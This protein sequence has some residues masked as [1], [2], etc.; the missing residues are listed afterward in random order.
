[1]RHWRS[2]AQRI[3]S[4]AIRDDAL[5]TIA[6]KRGH[7]DGAALFATLP[8]RRSAS[9]LRLLV[10]YELIWDFLDTVNEHGASAGQA[11]GRQL[12]LAL[13][14][15]VDP[16]RPV[17]DYYARHP[18][19]GDDGYLDALVES[20]RV[21]ALQLPSYQTVLPHLRREA[22]RAQVLAINHDPDTNRRDTTLRAWSARHALGHGDATWFEL[23]GAASASMT[24]HALFAL[25]AEADCS[26]R[27][28][29]RTCGAYFPWISAATTMLD[30][31]VDQ[32]E[33]A[34]SHDHSYIAHYRDDQAGVAR[35]REL[36]GGSLQHASALRH[37][38]RHMLI[39]A[40]MAAMYLSKDTA[41]TPQ[42]RDSTSAL[43]DAGGSLTR[44]LLP[45]LR[46][47]R[48]VYS[49]RGS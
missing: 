48:T 23:S 31:Y 14:D 32:E 13:I 40:C 34:V 36:I 2:R 11:N 18:W 42:M 1:M 15:A 21:N 28:I 24:I 9:L 39:I 3:A 43:I 37:G 4:E 10:S 27:E 20:C 5:R 38:E 35:V 41:R 45:I 33:D 49:Q 22:E 26:E 44:L 29:L 30:S 6:T 47:W 46:L 12:H 19:K 25:A 7:I 8:D 17:A 16:S